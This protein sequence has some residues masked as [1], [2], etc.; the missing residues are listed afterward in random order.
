LISSVIWGMIWTVV[1]PL[2]LDDRPV[3]LPRGDVVVRGELDVQ[4]PLVVPQVEVHLAP[5]REDVDL[6]VLG[7]VHGPCID[8]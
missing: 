3:H 2:P 7:R 8:V 4:E 5:V 6:A 1:P